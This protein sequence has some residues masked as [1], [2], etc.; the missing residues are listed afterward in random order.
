MKGIFTNAFEMGMK[1]AQVG[2]DMVSA[3][4]AHN[5]A[6]ATNTMI[7]NTSYLNPKRLELMGKIENICA[8][9]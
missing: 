7:F 4:E 3:V 8:G 6:V 9:M 1:L 2:L 5:S